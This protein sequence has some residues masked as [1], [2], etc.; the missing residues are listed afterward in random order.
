M[1]AVPLCQMKR[2][3]SIQCVGVIRDLRGSCKF[4]EWTSLY[5]GRV[6]R[7]VNWP[8]L[9]RRHHL[10]V[11]KQMLITRASSHLMGCPIEWECPA[12]AEVAM[13]L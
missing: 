3:F 5:I 6:G 9:Y 2:F 4:G 11:L 12:K 13:S 10:A 7:S 8:L 1:H